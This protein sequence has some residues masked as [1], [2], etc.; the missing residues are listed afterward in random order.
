M[1]ASAVYLKYLGTIVTIIM[2]SVFKGNGI[3]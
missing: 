2:T 3:L 1:E